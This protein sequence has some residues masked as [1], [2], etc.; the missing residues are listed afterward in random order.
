M[1]ILNHHIIIIHYSFFSVF[2]VYFID[3]PCSLLISK[4]LL[5]INQPFFHPIPTGVYPTK[6]KLIFPHKKATNF[7]I[8]QAMQANQPVD[9]TQLGIVTLEPYTNGR[10]Q[11]W[12]TSFYGMCAKHEIL[13]LL[14]HS[15]TFF[16]LL[17]NR[18]IF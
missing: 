15:I 5:P 2:I 10:D 18:S 1:T 13:F 17:I 14:G 9:Q 11:K 12:G 3:P 16:Y 4:K 7:L 6:I 8:I